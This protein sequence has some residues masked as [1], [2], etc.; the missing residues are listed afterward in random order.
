MMHEGCAHLYNNIKDNTFATIKSKPLTQRKS[1]YISL[2]LKPNYKTCIYNG[3]ACLLGGKL[4]K[5]GGIGP[6][7]Y[8]NW[9]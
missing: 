5:L 8:Q 1:K 3:H 9:G 7:F 6:Q 2:K 4:P